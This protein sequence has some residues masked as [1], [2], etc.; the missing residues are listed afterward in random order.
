MTVEGTK[1]LIVECACR[2]LASS[3]DEKS[4]ENMWM[5]DFTDR[6]ISERIH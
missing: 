1:V 4:K 2:I 5:S 6:S 3:A